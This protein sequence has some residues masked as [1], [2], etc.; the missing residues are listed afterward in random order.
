[1][2][3]HI[4]LAVD[5]GGTFTDVALQADGQ[6]HTAKVLTTPSAPADA[7][8]DGIGKL[9]ASAAIPADAIEVFVHG[10]TLPTNALIER[11]GAHTALLTTQGVRDAVEMAHENR[12][13]QYDLYMHRPEP[14]VP[15]HLRIG[16]PERFAADG[17]E[18]LALD[19]DAVRAAADTLAAEGIESIAVGYLHAYHSPQHEIRTGEIL[20]ECLPGVPLTLSSEVCPEIREYERFST[21]CAN[22][23]VA[24]LVKQYL[25]DLSQRLAEIGVGCEILLMQSGGGLGTLAEALRF[26]VR[27]IESGPAGGALL[28]ADMARDLNIDTALSFDMGGTTAKLCAIKNGNPRTSREFEVAR[29]YRYLAGSG[30]PLRL[31]VIEMVEIGAGGSSIAS[32]DSLGQIAVGPRSAGADPG[33][34]AYNLGGDQPTVTDADLLLGRLLPSRFAGGDLTLNL[35]AASAAV[36]KEIA[37][38]AGLEPL[39]AA[40]GITEVVDENMANAARTHT[41]EQGFGVAN[42]TLIAFGGAAPIHAAAVARK[43]GITDVVVPA[44]AGVGSAIGFLR[45]PASHESVRT[46]HVRVNDIK[47]TE[48]SDL[49]QEMANESHTVVAAAAPNAPTRT[50]LR[51]LMRYR[52]QGHEI[53]VEADPTVLIDAVSNGTAGSDATDD[54]AP[55]DAAVRAHL[56]ER[57][58]DSYQAMYTREIPGLE[59]EVLSWLMTVQTLVEAETSAQPQQADQPSEPTGQAQVTDIATGQATQFDVHDRSALALGAWIEGPALVVEDQTT[60]VVPAGCTATVIGDGHLRMSL[61]DARATD[62]AAT[63]ADQNSADRG[64]AADSAAAALA[65]I[66]LGIQWNRLISVVEEQ[67]RT[68]IKAAFSTS[69]REAGDLSAGVFDPAGR[70]LAQ[71]VTGTPGHV[72]SMAYSVLHFLDKF[73]TA[74]MSPGDI[75]ITNDPW[76]GTGHLF[77]IVVVTPTFRDGQLIALFACTSH[78]VDIGGLGFT[79]DSNEVFH[80]GLYLPLMKFATDGVFDANVVSIIEANVRDPIQVIGDVHSLAACNETG[81]KR[82]L[83]MM[84]EYDLADLDTLGEHIISRSRQAM[85]NA[86]RELPEGTWDSQMRIDG[87]EEPIDLVAKLS[88]KDDGIEVDYEGT[89][90]QSNWGINV[91][92]AYTDAY[93]SFGVRCI[94]GPEVPNNAGSLEVVRVTAPL[95]SIL[96]APH[97]AA[98]AVRHVIGQMLP[99]TIF[100]ALAQ[101]VPERVPAEGTSALWFMLASGSWIPPRSRASRASDGAEDAD[102][103]DDETSERFILLSFHSGGA[104]AR[105]R[106]DGLSA[107]AFP[108]GVR[109]MPIEV[110]EIGSPLVFWRKEFR[111]DSGGTGKYRGGLGQVI[112][113]ENRQ[114]DDFTISATYERVDFAARGRHGGGDG[115]KGNVTLDDGTVVNSKGRSVISGDRRLI[116]EFPGGGGWGDPSER[117][118][119]TKERDRRLG[120]VTSD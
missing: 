6:L 47:A 41:A 104:G 40:I 5:I 95:G 7:V 62:K 29:E 69:T 64:A 3:A 94:V 23:Y 119:A 37:Q 86:V 106:A 21:V 11:R 48:L 85:L 108:S 118:A 4:K 18:L 109:N 92:M 8:L 110:N 42:G 74:E 120:Y 22:A 34:A 65:E 1:M 103:A 80:E 39:A 101:V 93:T 88:I 33:P 63:S 102:G 20:A 38:G 112:E 89:S 111:A 107:T 32:L 66:H 19:E 113:L 57:F 14:L 49:L 17:T 44:N 76:K 114:G 51:A 99:D 116:V 26:P 84:D 82:L 12:F 13:E 70:M 83:E 36:D 46:R 117:D 60:T 100:G 50:I 59:V 79:T 25:T 16:I 81:A 55:D 115:A 58:I 52:G 71:S 87:I 10:T 35:S 73:P 91:P 54:R 28:A 53:T 77:D 78:V 30:L 75:F 56:H 61:H 98:V 96:N 97:P 43:L 27:L 15:R 45:A 90:G 72:N 2:A 31:P 68:L 24:P 67:A 9:L 105:P